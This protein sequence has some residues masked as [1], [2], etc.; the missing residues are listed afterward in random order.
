MAFI[1][2]NSQEL[3]CKIVYFGPALAGKCT[4]LE[5][6][7]HY[8]KTNPT[9]ENLPQIVR[10][11]LKT[12][13]TDFIC[14]FNVVDLQKTKVNSLKIRFHLYCL[15][16]AVFYRESMKLVLK[17]ADGVV[18]VADSQIGRT[19]A[20]HD[21][22]QALKEILLEDGRNILDFPY[23]LQLNKRDL[24]T[25]EIHSVT[26]MKNLFCIKHEPIV[27]TIAYKGIGVLE[28][29]NEISNQVYNYLQRID[30][31]QYPSK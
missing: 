4:T 10:Y 5:Y 1:D 3:N 23:M 9:Y 21:F 22:L 17:G 24:P 16:G 25:L 19:D 8:M 31:S 12:N 28:T 15:T 30:I 29:Y 6:I 7:Y 20:N 2:I 18:F 14:R 27:E 11:I 26:S 13:Q